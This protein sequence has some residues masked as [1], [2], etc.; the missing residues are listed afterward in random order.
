MIIQKYGG[1]SVGTPARIRKVAARIAET[2]REGERVVVVVSAMGQTTDQLIALAHRVTASP[3]A[4][5]LDM[6]VANGETISAPLLAMCLAALGVPAI[7]LTGLQA[8]VRT[9]GHH[10]KARI[11]AVETDRLRAELEA[12][13]VCVVAGFQGVTEDLEITTLG[14]GGSD[15]TAVALAA[16]LNASVCEIYTDVDAIYSADPRVVKRARRIEHISYEEMLEMAAVGAR[17]LHPRAVEIGQLYSIPIH[18]RSSFKKRPGTMI[19]AELPMEER[20]RVR[21]VAHETDIAK[22]T[23]VGVP[24]R[25][26]VAATIFEPLGEAAISV[27]VIVQS[28]SET[29]ETDI[30]FTIAESD[31]KQAVP[32]VR[33]AAETVGAKDVK[34]SGG[35]A[36]LSIVGTGM[37]G[38]PGVA[39]R[40]FR[41]LAEGGI[42]IEGISTSEIRI[43]CLVSNAQAEA[44]VRALHTAFELDSLITRGKR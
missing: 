1:T 35:L 18:V 5:E 8:G 7:S 14:R 43:T 20:S 2:V 17:V 21:G 44:G 27:D 37:L 28:V 38:T 40:M 34:A 12:G 15:T 30:T 4:R 42:N 23:I 31:L 22:V 9:S 41:T 36:K 11:R 24:D 32:L 13:R 39:G 6:L 19:V 25:P 33:R 16:A 29:R 3:P 10:S 26:G